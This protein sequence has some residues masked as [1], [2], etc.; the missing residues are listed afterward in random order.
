MTNIDV[1]IYASIPSGGGFI[2]RIGRRIDSYTHTIQSEGGFA[3]ASFTMP[4]SVEEATLFMNMG[5]GL[6]VRS[7]LA[8]LPVWEGFVDRIDIAFG[9]ASM[10]IGPLMDVVNKARTTYSIHQFAG[11]GSG[12]QAVTSFSSDDGAQSG[13]FVLEGDIAGGEL[14]GPPEAEAIRDLYLSEYS[15]PRVNGDFNPGGEAPIVTFSCLGYYRLFEKYYY[16]NAVDNYVEALDKMKDVIDADPNSMFSSKNGYFEEVGL[17]VNEY[18]DW[19]RTGTDIIFDIMSYGNS[20][21]ERT[22]FGVYEGRS[23]EFRSVNSDVTYEIE[24]GTN[25]S[26]ISIGGGSYLHP[27]LVRPGHWLRNRSTVLPRG[28]NSGSLVFI[29]TLSFNAPN[30]LSI[31]GGAFDTFTQRLARAQY[32]LI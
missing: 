27:S 14:S 23:I 22:M 5:V 15:R 25:G 21:G 31:N 32:F 1:S 2:G 3:S 28:E 18:E 7:R 30:E 10:S 16:L 20:L 19:S 11:I 6:H 29:E 26:S 24:L 8:G 13:F 17:S 9:G 12:G 4:V